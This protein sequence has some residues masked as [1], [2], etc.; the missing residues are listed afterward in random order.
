MSNNYVEKRM[1]FHTKNLHNNYVMEKICVISTWSISK[2]INNSLGDIRMQL[3][4][5][6]VPKLLK[7]QAL[8]CT[9]AT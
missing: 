8:F 6:K 4:V 7:A 3:I 1:D 2:L 5:N 9:S